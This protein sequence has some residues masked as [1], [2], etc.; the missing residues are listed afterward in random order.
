MDGNQKEQL[1]ALFK[2]HDKD[3]SGFLSHDEIRLATRQIYSSIDLQLSDADLDQLIHQV[4]KNN[5]GKVAFQEFL[6]LL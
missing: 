3:N 6:N 2:E 5:D 1:L 4:D